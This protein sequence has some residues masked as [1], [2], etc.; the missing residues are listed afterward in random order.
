[1]HAARLDL[2]RRRVGELLP[3]DTIV[4]VWRDG[5]MEVVDQGDDVEDEDAGGLPDRVG[6]GRRSPYNPAEGYEGCV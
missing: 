2:G 1:M 3:V 4:R 6:V 5:G